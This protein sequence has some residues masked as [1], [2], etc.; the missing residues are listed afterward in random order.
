MLESK[1]QARIMKGLKTAG[2][3]AIKVIVGNRKGIPDISCCVP[4]NKEQAMKHFETH[5]TLGI[6][7]SLEV[8]N[9]TGKP[10]DL[11]LWNIEEIRK[12]GGVAEVVHS[13]NEVANILRR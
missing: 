6:F 11:Q 13:W 9:E 12:C 10:T 2:I 3:Y 5:E 8:K 7:V 4:I 1:I